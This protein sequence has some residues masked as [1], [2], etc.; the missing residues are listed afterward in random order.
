MSEKHNE[1]TYFKPLLEGIKDLEGVVVSVDALHPQREHT[2]Y[3]HSR[4]AH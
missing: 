4:E 3:L 1:I 2:E